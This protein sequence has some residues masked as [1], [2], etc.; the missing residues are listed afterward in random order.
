MADEVLFAR[1]GSTGDGTSSWWEL[2]VGQKSSND[3]SFETDDLE[4]ACEDGNINV[5]QSGFEVLR[6]EFLTREVIEG[7]WDACWTGDT[8][9]R[10]KVDGLTEQETLMNE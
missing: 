2:L 8:D 1:G 9:E 4:K 5:G 6:S 7:L 3:C 10:V